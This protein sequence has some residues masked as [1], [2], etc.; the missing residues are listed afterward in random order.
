MS[1]IVDPSIS[2]NDLITWINDLLKVFV[3]HYSIIPNIL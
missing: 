2:R 1:E 3:Y